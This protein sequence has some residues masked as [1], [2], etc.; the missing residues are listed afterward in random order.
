MSTRATPAHAGALKASPNAGILNSSGRGEAEWEEKTNKKG[1]CQQFS[2]RHEKCVSDASSKGKGLPRS[3]GKG[4]KRG[5]KKEGCWEME[6]SQGWPS[7]PEP[8]TFP[9]DTPGRREAPRCPRSSSH[10]QP[11]HVVTRGV[12]PRLQNGC[13]SLSCGDPAVPKPSLGRDGGEVVTRGNTP[14]RGTHLSLQGVL[15]PPQTHRPVY[16]P[17]PRPSPQNLPRR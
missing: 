16:P 12:T 11:G 6:G 17:Q 2:A 3:R 15:P 10:P 5:G 13:G 7:G 4:K 8:V 9:V 1:A 14:H